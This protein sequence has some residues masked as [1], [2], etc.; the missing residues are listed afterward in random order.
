MGVTKA[1]CCQP[2]GSCLESTGAGGWSRCIFS[3]WDYLKRTKHLL[4]KP[5]TAVWQ[6]WRMPLIPAFR[7]LRQADLCEFKA[8][9]VYKVLEEPGLTHWEILFW[10]TKPN[11]NLLHPRLNLISVAKTPTWMHADALFWPGF[12]SLRSLWADPRFAGRP[13]QPVCPLLPSSLLLALFYLMTYPE[14]RVE[15]ILILSI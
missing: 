14:T 3:G 4:S 6:W 1:S 2:G 11:P 10:K 12:R 9:L 15:N 13:L 5:Y 7:R 8:S